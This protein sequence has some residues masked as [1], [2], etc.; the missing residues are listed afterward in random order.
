MNVK[1]LIV[2]YLSDCIFENSI[3][4]RKKSVFD[5]N[6]SLCQKLTETLSGKS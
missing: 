3:F 1:F 6:L 5:V 4:E 2:N